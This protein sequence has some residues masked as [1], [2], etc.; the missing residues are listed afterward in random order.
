MTDLRGRRLWYDHSIKGK[1][2]IEKELISFGQLQKAEEWQ[3]EVKGNWLQLN[4]K[5]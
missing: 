3:T 4:I 5:N 1:L 2:P